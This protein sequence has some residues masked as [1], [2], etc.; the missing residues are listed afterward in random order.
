MRLNKYATFLLGISIFKTGEKRSELVTELGI[1]FPFRPSVSPIRS[2]ATSNPTFSSRVSRIQPNSLQ[3][4]NN[5][6]SEASANNLTTIPVAKR[7]RSPPLPREDQV[8]NGNSNA[9]QDGT[10]R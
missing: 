1:C 10:E 2:N 8:F 6:F 5:T 4:S 7:M 9:T 3:S